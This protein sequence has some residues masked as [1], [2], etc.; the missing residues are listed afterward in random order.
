MGKALIE[1]NPYRALELNPKDSL[2][3]ITAEL[4]DRALA[5]H[6]EER[7]YL[8]GAWQRDRKSVV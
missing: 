4:Q 6:P 3:E 5:M 8:Q 1:E 2:A 7:A